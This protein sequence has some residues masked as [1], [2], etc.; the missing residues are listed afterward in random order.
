MIV[1]NQ[2]IKTTEVA[3]EVG[4]D[5][6]KLARSQ[7]HILGLCSFGCCWRMSQDQLKA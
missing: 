4:Y 3:Q 5:G 1:D 6:A 2:S 7:A